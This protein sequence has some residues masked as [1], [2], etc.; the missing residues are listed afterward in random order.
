MGIEARHAYRFGYL[1]SEDWQT[2]RISALARENG[3]C[4]ICREFSTSNDAH[5][6]EYPSNIYHTKTE[7]LVILCRPCHD[8]I[9]A[10]LRITGV[11]SQTRSEFIEFAEAFQTWINERNNSE[12]KKVKNMAVRDFVE[13]KRLQQCR[14]CGV[15]SEEFPRYNFFESIKGPSK[16][17]CLM[18]SDCIEEVKEMLS[19]PLPENVKFYE[20]YAL[21]KKTRAKKFKPN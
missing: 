3:K 10:V 19:K 16:F 21:W 12:I 17:R 2:V 4:Q 6:I 13:G 11:K 5:H 8:L 1:R 9:H 15:E 14:G 18:C 7:H 20:I